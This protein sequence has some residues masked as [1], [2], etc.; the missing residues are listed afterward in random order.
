MDEGVRKANEREGGEGE[1]RIISWPR[2][3]QGVEG[4]EV[5]GKSWAGGKQV[6]ED[7]ASSVPLQ[8][9]CQCLCLLAKLFLDHKTLYYDVSTFTEVCVNTFNEVC[10][11]AFT[12]VCISNLTLVCMSTFT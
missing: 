1:S 11:R 2:R 9:Y 10:V 4:G 6:R 5:G 7:R 12:V 3:G 8:V